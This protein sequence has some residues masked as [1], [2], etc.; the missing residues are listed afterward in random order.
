MIKMHSDLFFSRLHAS[1]RIHA[2]TE[3]KDS[4]ESVK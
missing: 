1:T 3:V 4:G 2:Y